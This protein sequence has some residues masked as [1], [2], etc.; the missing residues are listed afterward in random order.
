MSQSTIKTRVVG[1]DIS[2]EQTVYAIVDMRGNIIAKQGF[3]T[4]DFS[5]ANDFVKPG[6]SPFAT[7]SLKQTR[8][9]PYFFNTAC[10]RP[11]ILQRV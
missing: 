7:F 5:T 9:I 10:G 6:I 4:T 1:I 8:Q 11:Q 2:I 3:A